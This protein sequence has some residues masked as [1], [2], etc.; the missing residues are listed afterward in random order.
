MDTNNV[1]VLEVVETKKKRSFVPDS[2][3]I[4]AWE[5]A[6]KTGKGAKEC[7]EKTG[8]SVNSVLARASKM[9]SAGVALSNLPRGNRSN[10]SSREKALEILASLKGTTVEVTK[11]EGD[12]LIAKAAE[13]KANKETEVVSK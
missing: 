8:L 6:V 7:A 12:K 10:A 9:R 3:F 1:P 11:A 4:P 13:R 2:V 5:A